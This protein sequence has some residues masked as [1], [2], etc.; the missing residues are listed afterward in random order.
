MFTNDALNYLNKFFFETN[1]AFWICDQ[2]RKISNTFHRIFSC[3][4]DEISILLHHSKILNEFYNFVVLFHY[5]KWCALK[6][7][8]CKNNYKRNLRHFCLIEHN[9]ILNWIC[10]KFDVLIVEISRSQTSIFC[11]ISRFNFIILK[12]NIIID[13]KDAIIDLNNAYIMNINLTK[14]EFYK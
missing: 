7:F 6:V 4:R 13:L 11:F 2:K 10:S 1:E 9:V 5:H 14:F 3:A 12:K 8:V